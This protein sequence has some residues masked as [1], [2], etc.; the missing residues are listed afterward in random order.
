MSEAETVL[1]WKRFVDELMV[2]LS[3]CDKCVERFTEVYAHQVARYG[4][5]E[6]F[7]KQKPRLYSFLKGFTDT[8]KALSIDVGRTDRLAN[9]GLV[10]E[11]EPFERTANVIDSAYRRLQ[12]L[13]D[14]YSEFAKR[15]EVLKSD[16]KDMLD[17][18]QA[19]KSFAQQQKNS[20]ISIHTKD[21]LHV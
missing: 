18:L 11:H 8:A 16:L 9:T 2:R 5:E 10:P 14:S 13:F 20:H 3:G 17:T 12:K 19:C 6:K 15:D 7:S 21:V 1:D 4:S